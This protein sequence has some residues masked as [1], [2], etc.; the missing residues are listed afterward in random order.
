MTATVAELQGDA[1]EG[2]A[3]GSSRQTCGGR[4]TNSQRGLTRAVSV[5]GNAKPRGHQDA[6][7]RGLRHAGKVHVLTQGDLVCESG[8][9]VSRGRSS[10]EAMRK[11]GRAKDR[12]VVCEAGPLSMEPATRSPNVSSPKR[13][14]PAGRCA[15]P[16]CPT[17]KP[18][19]HSGEG[20]AGNH[21]ARRQR[22][23]KQEMIVVRATA[24]TG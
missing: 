17:V 19:K 22:Q 2:G 15:N 16:K 9:G 4:N 13:I 21:A 23:A 3:E 20:R 5:R 10:D 6:E 11:H 18:C 14:E 7:G 12:R 1:R 24:L 8:Q